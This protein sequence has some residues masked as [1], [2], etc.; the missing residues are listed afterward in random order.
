MFLSSKI[1]KKSEKITLLDLAY[2][3]VFFIAVDLINLAAQYRF[4][5]RQ[6]DGLRP[7]DREKSNIMSL[8]VCFSRQNAIIKVI[9]MPS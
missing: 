6:S 3:V 9:R 8:S 7:A 1:Y 5:E 4:S 2:L